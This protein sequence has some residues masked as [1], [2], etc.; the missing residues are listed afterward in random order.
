MF[1]YLQAS[2]CVAPPTTGSL[3]LSWTWR[4]WETSTDPRELRQPSNVWSS[5]PR[6]VSP[7]LPAGTRLS[8]YSRCIYPLSSTVW[9]QTMQVWYF[10]MCKTLISGQR[11]LRTNAYN[12]VAQFRQLVGL[13]WKKN[14]VSSDCKHMGIVYGLNVNFTHT[15]CRFYA[16]TE[17]KWEIFPPHNSNIS[18]PVTGTYTL[19]FFSVPT[20]WM[21]RR[22]RYC[23]VST[24]KISRSPLPISRA[25]GQRWSCPERGRVTMSTT[26]LPGRSLASVAL[27]VPNLLTPLFSGIAKFGQDRDRWYYHSILLL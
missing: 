3:R 24:C 20:R 5:T 1:F 13:A 7:S 15:I 19:S 12:K 4:E 25:M 9:W 2:C 26:W 21:E 10:G 23:R 22:T 6:P 16:H 14:K 8:T 18:Y 11:R 17:S 27:E